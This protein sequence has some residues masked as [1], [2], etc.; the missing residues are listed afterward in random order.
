MATIAE[1]RQKYPQ[2]SDMSDDALAGALHSKFYSDM[3]REE[4]NA[5]IGY[6]PA[7]APAAPAAPA[8]APDI[9]GGNPM[10]D[11][12]GMGGAPYV[13]TPPKP[14]PTVA[15]NGV[16]QPLDENTGA[17]WSV[18]MMV[19]GSPQQD[20][21]ANI[22]RYFPDAQPHGED[23]FVFKDPKTGRPT[24]YNP[25]GFDFGDVASVGR[26][27]SQA[28]GATLGGAAAGLGS[29]PTGGLSAPV[30]VPLAAGT[31]SMMAGQLWDG[32]AKLF[33]GQI[34]TRT[35]LQTGLEAA[36]DVGMEGAA[37]GVGNA[38]GAIAREGARRGTN[39]VRSVFA[40]PDAAGRAADLIEAGVTP[41]AGL[42]SDKKIIQNTD[43]VLANLPTSANTMEAATQRTRNEI[44]SGVKDLAGQYAGGTAPATKETIG[45]T[46]QQGVKNAAQRFDAR[47]EKLYDTAFSKIGAD[48]PSKL[49]NVSALRD[50]LQA[51]IAKA[52]ESLSPTAGKAMQR[53]D[54]I[55]ADAKNTG[56]V[57]FDALRQ[58]RTDIGRDIKDPLLAGSSSA[59]N[60]ALKRVYGALSEDMKATASAAS[61]EARQALD[62]A[63]R[64]TRYNMK[65][66]FEPSQR[67]ADAATPEQALNLA[68]SG[69]KDGGTQ[70]RRLR[71]TLTPEEW[72]Q[73]SGGVLNRL[74]LAKAGQQGA[75]GEAFSVSQLLTNWN[76][77]SPEAKSALFDG[78][79]YKELRPAL[80]KLTKAAEYAKDV[81]KLANTSGTAR[82]QTYINLLTGG[83]ATGAVAS[84]DP[85]AMGGAALAIA[86]PYAAAKLMTSPAFAR[87]LATTADQV[88]KMDPMKAPERIAAQLTRLKTIGSQNPDISGLIDQYISGVSSGLQGQ[89]PQK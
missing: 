32:I 72:N 60:D 59:Q 23:N 25:K 44:E 85:T 42:V 12:G 36:T 65:R 68:M 9:T 39:A 71:N 20:R 26:E 1:I 89:Q 38:V 7:A 70:L 10:G 64:Y 4:F 88:V 2:Y 81:D 45:E 52:P 69:A 43:S 83:V 30:A 56:A 54:A 48:T 80:D 24:L 34:D 77:L 8:A 84:G 19:G 61:P 15:V 33:N 29:I 37:T 87:W 86:T 82:H 67:I 49:D 31:G 66:V 17:P 63:D 62:V 5:K 13:Y 75:E 58:I 74:G 35:P 21:L 47:Q 6:T 27:A 18:R 14:V 46:V 11:A 3:P 79:A 22:Q 28:V 16:Q 73:V 76:S 40:S 41:R 57:P 51:A 50:E 78:G 55:L 53:L